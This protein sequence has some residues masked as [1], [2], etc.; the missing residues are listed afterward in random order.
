MYEKYMICTRDFCNVTRDGNTTGFQVKIRINYYRG[1]YLSMID[2][3]RL[4]VDGQE[5]SPEEMTFGVSNRTYSFAELAKAKEARWF[6]G[7]P[8]TLTVRKPGGLSPGRHKVEL[9][10]FI[11]NSY[12]PRY[13][14]EGLCNFPG[15]PRTPDGATHWGEPPNPLPLTARKYITLVQ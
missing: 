11:R 3:L 10:L 6:F 14:R 8:A 15:L 1:C 4:A 2:T 9:G 7:D 13:D 5:F 12:V